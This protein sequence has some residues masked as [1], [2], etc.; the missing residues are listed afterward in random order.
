[1]HFLDPNPQGHPAVLLLHGLGVNASS[2]TLQLPALTAAGFRPIAPDAPG[3]GASPYDGRGWTI[4]R[5]AAEMA[6]LIQE[7]GSG[8]AHVVG[9]SMGGIIAQQFALDTPALTRKLVLVSTFAILLPDSLNGWLYFLQRF[10]LVNTLGLSAQARAVAWRIF[11]DPDNATLRGMLVETISHADPRAYRRAM[12]AL[13][14]FNSV[15]RLGEIKAPTLVM[16][17]KDDTTV[18][19]DRQHLL[20]NGI[21]DARQV[22]IPDAGHAVP[23]DQSEIFNRELLEFLGEK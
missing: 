23:V 5:V 4:C 20:V 7:L 13:G 8:P 17:G 14:L 1:M 3:F 19:P 16:T 18:S 10:I 6:G 21:P 9:L 15:K 22:L 2:W 11:P 12:T